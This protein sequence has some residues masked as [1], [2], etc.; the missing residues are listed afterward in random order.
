MIGLAASRILL[1]CGLARALPEL[2]RNAS[3]K[4]TYK[5]CMSQHFNLLNVLRHTP[6]DLLKLYALRRGI[7]ARFDWGER[8]A[9]DADRVAK[10]LKAEGEEVYR[11]TVSEFRRL[12]K[13]KGLEFTHGVFNE[14]R[15]HRDETALQTLQTL[16]S[17]LAQALWT[18][19]ERPALIKNAKIL[20]DI[21]KLPNGAWLKYAHMPLR[22]GAVSSVVEQALQDALVQF[23]TENQF[24]GSNCKVDCL[25]R[26]DENVFYAYS[27]D[28]P[29]SDLSFDGGV[30]TSQIVVPVFEII[31]KYSNAKRT[32]EIYL[33]GDR[34]VGPKLRV[35]FARAVLGEEIDEH[36]NEDAPIYDT[37]RVLEPGFS[38]RYSADLGIAGVRI[39]KMR[40][41]VEGTP[42]LR[43][44]AEADTLD[45]EKSLH[46]VLAMLSAH[47]PN[48]PLFPDQLC[49]DVIFHPQGRDRRASHRQVWITYPN[50]LR[51]KR[52][53]LSDRISEMLLQC[54]IEGRQQDD[55]T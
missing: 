40:I 22:P 5:R 43:V 4:S 31:F 49:L 15:F 51:V 8:P 52:D 36:I 18:I 11:S 47:F 14:A 19:L 39:T 28:H 12:W 33:G 3:S 29:D 9:V 32:L 16:K 2:Q 20:R 41:V 7:L 34:T 13:L 54:G 45:N 30:L 42:W 35:L 38:F 1:P 26:D 53:D 6:K 10:A 25:L 37:R 55:G 23:F 44:T 46:D 48:R 17:H 24:R 21:D 27:E 50:S